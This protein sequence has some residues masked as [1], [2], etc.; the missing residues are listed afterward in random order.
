MTAADK[1]TEPDQSRTIGGF[2]PSTIVL[3][4]GATCLA[5]LIWGAVDSNWVLVA[6]EAPAVVALG[7]VW[8]FARANESGNRVAIIAAAIGALCTVEL[9][10]A[11][12]VLYARG[13]T[14]AIIVAVSTGL[15]V[16]IG[17]LWALVATRQGEPR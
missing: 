14:L 11:T 3:F 13:T 4:V 17:G 16:A 2:A 6:T 1:I 9:W 12:A 5:G 15:T 10:I 7:F 8:L